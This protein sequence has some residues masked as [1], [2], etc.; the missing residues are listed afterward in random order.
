MLMNEKRCVITGLG[1]VCAIG[2]DTEEC[3][4]A[5][6]DGKS[7]IADAASFDT[8]ECYSHKGAEVKLTD[9]E[10]AGGKYD[11]TT[12]LGIKAAGEAIRDAGIDM[13]SEDASEIGVL[14]GSCIAGAACVDK[15]Y[16]Q[17]EAGEKGDPNDILSISA[18]VIAGNVADY[19]NAGGI[20]ANIVNACAAGTLSIALAID[21]I[22]GGKGEIF[23][24][25]GCD[26]FSSLAYAGFHAL[27]AL[28]PSDCS[29]FNHSDGITLGEGAGVLVV[30]SYEHA[31]KRGAKIY[32][33][34]LGSGVSSDAYHITAPRPDG[35]GQMSVITRAVKNSGLKFTDIDYVNAHGTGTAKNDESEF[36]SL[37]TL[38]K[39]NKDLYVSSTKSM[40]GHC[41]GAAGAIEAVITVKALT[42]GKLPPTT[43][44]SEEDLK[45]LEEKSGDINFIANKPVQREINYAMSNSFA[46]G[47]NN[48]SI[49]FARDPNILNLSCPKQNLYVTGIG[50]VSGEY[51]EAKGD[52]IAKLDTETFKNYGIKSAFLRKLDRLSQLQLL[53]G[54]RALEDA[55]VTVTEEN[56]GIIGICIGTND[57]PMTEIANFQKGIIRE[58]IEKGSAFAFP[59]TVY[60]AAGG[61]LSI[62]TG[63]KGYNVTI[64]NGY[65]SGL[66]SVCAAAGA[67]MFGYESIMLASGTDE[68]TE[69]DDEIYSDL[70]L[71]G[72]GGMKLGEGSVTCVIEKDSSAAERGAKRYAKIAGFSSTRDTSGDR[73]NN[74]RL[75]EKALTKAIMNVLE[76]G[77]MKVSDVSCIYGFGNGIESIDNFEMEVYK[78][79]FGDGIEVKLVKK[80]YGEA[81]AASSSMQFAMLARDIYEGKVTN[82]IAVSYG[83]SALYSAVLLTK[84]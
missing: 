34:V 26:S 81:R 67:I 65:Q 75:S 27:R 68:C 37:N 9:E 24:A 78:K 15:Y 52:Y 45:V 72:E 32:C 53:S 2:N 17:K 36:L 83:T 70:G 41:L 23:L 21:L 50:I 84:A 25:G 69:I 38:F 33:D 51:D 73:T 79:I 6:L 57:G 71:T 35:E 29:P 54:I 47:G 3:F 61:Y 58:G 4:R 48:A 31:V 7:G 1:L 66:Q 14:L 44:Y 43:G 11:R 39:D 40:T 74:T 18:T 60:N 28:S 16:N 56:E 80:E 10:L 12:A 13:D 49:V 19:Y 55:G 62:A 77:G 30:E 64:A 82:G 20:T 59:N 42:E 22:R 63:I 8:T 5:A 46:F 76:E